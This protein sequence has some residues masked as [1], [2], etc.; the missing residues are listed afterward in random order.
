M[1]PAAVGLLEEKWR[2]QHACFLLVFY[3]GASNRTASLGK[4]FLFLQMWSLVFPMITSLKNAR[5][6]AE[7]FESPF[8]MLSLFNTLSHG[9]FVPN[10]ISNSNFQLAMSKNC[11]LAN[12]IFSTSS[13]TFPWY[14]CS[15]WKI[16][17]C[18]LSHGSPKRIT[19]VINYLAFQLKTVRWWRKYCETGIFKHALPW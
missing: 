5:I 13:V 14:F 12:L 9:S 11:F 19:Y 7:I 1:Q 6:S 3:L 4:K 17:L 10:L 18:T 8:V 2:I 16:Y 15:Y